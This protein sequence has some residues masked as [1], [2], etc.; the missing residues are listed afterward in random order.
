[1]EK[2]SNYQKDIESIRELMERSIKF[3]SLSGLSGILAGC[4]ALIGA[5]VAYAIIQ[6][7]LSP[8]GYRQESVQD[9]PIIIKLLV[10]ALVVLIV[11][12][13]TGY[14]LAS[15]KATKSG[16]KVWNSASKKLLVNLAVPLLTGGV[17]ILFL[18]FYGH[19][20][21][22]APACLIFYG[23][24]LVNASPNLF[25]EFRYLGYTEIILGLISTALPGYGLIFWA[26]GFGV[27]HIIYG[28]M[29]FKKYDR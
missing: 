14:F 27:L 4:Y 16:T 7:P 29:M 11:S 28:A 17:F 3:V 20:G 1:M 24:A 23:L 21:I 6:Y 18:L 10:I 5:A 19:F 9:T 15:K 8:I 25:D 22:A 2:N 13:G 26:I 12:I